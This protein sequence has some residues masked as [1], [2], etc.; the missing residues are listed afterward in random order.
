MGDWPVLS[1]TLFSND[2]VS[3]GTYKTALNSP[4][5]A[6]TKG[7]YTQ[8]VA[9]APFDVAGILLQ[10]Q[11]NTNTR[12]FVDIAVGAVAS[13]VVVVPNIPVMNQGGA[14]TH[15]IAQKFIPIFIRKG[16]RIS[17]RQQGASGG[18]F[19]ALKFQLLA[20]GGFPNLQSPSLW[21]DWGSVLGTTSLTTL[22]GGAVNTKGAYAQL[23]AAT[24]LTS[25]W[26][27]INLGI[28][29]VDDIATDVAVGGA[30]SEVVV[31]P[32]MYSTNEIIVPYVLLPWS[33]RQ[34]QRVAA[35]C[36]AVGGASTI[37]IQILGGG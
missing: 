31:I 17:A 29:T 35:R 37:G 14:G 7:S 25:R 6:N 8:V 10:A 36:A 33:V 2:D 26:V 4:V 27:M 11:F 15:S 3:P 18:P 23:I 21:E 1:H 13:E 34:G 28:G 22:T 30:G 12:Q 5:S 19:M 32:N 20:T 24:G 16:S 9:S